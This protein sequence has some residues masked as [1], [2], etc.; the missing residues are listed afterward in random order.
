MGAIQ[1]AVELD[2]RRRRLKAQDDKIRELFL[3][4]TTRE[5]NILR[6][7]TSGKLN[8]EIADA[9][10]ISARTVE[11][12]RSRMMQKVG[13]RNV[14]DLIRIALAIDCRMS[15]QGQCGHGTLGDCHL[16]GSHIADYL[17]SISK[18]PAGD[19]T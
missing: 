9:E 13:A 12:Q 8:R 18:L 10:E 5:R 7:V 15:G 14:Q 16:D 19:S 11:Q 2:R 17:L 6:M 4:L 3:N 1:R